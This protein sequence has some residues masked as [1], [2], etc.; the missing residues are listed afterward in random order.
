MKLQRKQSRNTNATWTD[1]KD[2]TTEED[3]T[4]RTIVLII[5]DIASWV[6]T[7]SNTVKGFFLDLLPLTS[8]KLKKTYSTLK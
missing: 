4:E 7:N 5:T 8:L 1:E 3:P 2:Y 6:L